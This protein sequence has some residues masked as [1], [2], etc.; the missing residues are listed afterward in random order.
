[1][2]THLDGPKNKQYHLRYSK[3]VT[4]TWPVFTVNLQFVD[5]AALDVVKSS[6]SKKFHWFGGKDPSIQT[7]LKYLIKM[8][9]SKE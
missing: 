8:N 2:K 9:I 5:S 7:F 4:I 1:M 6:L 3:A